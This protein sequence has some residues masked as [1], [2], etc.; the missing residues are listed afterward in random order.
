MTVSTND[1][2]SLENTWKRFSVGLA[3]G[4]R[5]SVVIEFTHYQ[6]TP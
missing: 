3:A 1:S 2:D 6:Y 5:E 4:L